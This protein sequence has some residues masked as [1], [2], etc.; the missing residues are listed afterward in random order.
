MERRH[1]TEDF[2]R[3]EA[4]NGFVDRRGRLAACE[5]CAVG[6]GEQPDGETGILLQDGDNALELPLPNCWRI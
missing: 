2:D 5:S 4:E 3:P 6:Q 1:Q